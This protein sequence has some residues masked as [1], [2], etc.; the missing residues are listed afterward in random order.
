MNESPFNIVLGKRSSSGEP[1]PDKT[2]LS[3][4][5]S[6]K[7]PYKID[8]DDQSEGVMQDQKLE[9]NKY[10]DE[11]AIVE[12]DESSISSESFQM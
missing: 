3:K 5:S 10:I 8:E 12:V 4:D 11:N 6:S 2:S 7:S 9:M 1:S